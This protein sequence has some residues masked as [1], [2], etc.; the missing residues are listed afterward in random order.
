MFLF[1]PSASHVPAPVAPVAPVASV[2]MQKCYI[3]AGPRPNVG[4]RLQDRAGVYVRLDNR[5][6]SHLRLHCP[7]FLNVAC[8][9][10]YQFFYGILPKIKLQNEFSHFCCLR[11]NGIYVSCFVLGDRNRVCALFGLVLFFHFFYVL[12]LPFCLLSA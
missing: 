11:I 7:F 4:Q 10:G 3:N 6:H 1:L 8:L 2:D 9:W 12:L 5:Q